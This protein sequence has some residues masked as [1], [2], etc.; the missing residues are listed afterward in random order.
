MT[1]P[2]RPPGVP[3][4][5]R[6][7][8]E[9]EENYRWEEG[10]RNERGERHG[11]NR[12]WA[13][14]GYL[15]GECIYVDGKVEGP[16]RVFHPDGRLASVGEW[17]GGQ[18]YDVTFY[19]ARGASP[20]PWPPEAGPGVASVRYCSRDAVSNFATRY[21]DQDGIEVCENGDPIPPR[22]EGVDADAGFFP[23][24]GRWIVGNVKR[25]ANQRVG[26]CKQWTKD[27]T[28]LEHEELDEQGRMVSA[29]RYHESGALKRQQEYVGGEL[30]LD[31]RFHEDGTPRDREEFDDRGRTTYAADWREN[32]EL[33]KE[34]RAEWEGDLLL[35]FSE[36][37]EDGLLCQAERAGDALAC[38]L[39]DEGALA[40]EGLVA[41]GRRVGRW[42]TFDPPGGAV[43]TEADLT[44]HEVETDFAGSANWKDLYR[45]ARD[46]FARHLAPTVKAPELDGVDDIAWDEVG[47]CYGTA[48]EFPLLLRAV[49][50]PDPFVRVFGLR[51]I[52]RQIEHQGSVYPATAAVVPFLIR[53]LGNENVA[54]ED[55][56]RVLHDVGTAASMYRK[57][58]EESL[59]RA[60]AKATA[61]E[62][63]TPE[64]AD[65]EDPEDV[66]DNDEEAEWRDALLGTLDAIGAGL[67]A[68]FALAEKGS[69]DQRQYI[70]GLAGVARGGPDVREHL[71]A[72][73]RSPDASLRAMASHAGV[74]NGSLTAD[75]GTALL[76]D[77]APV[78][79][80]VTAFAL[81]RR[82]GPGSPPVVV[83]RLAELVERW[84]DVNPEF[85]ALP[86]V[87]EHLL[88][89]VALALGVIR[90][91]AAF[92]LAPALCRTIDS[93]DGMSAS[94]CGHGLLALAFGRCQR[95][96]MPGFLDVLEAL[97]RSTAFYTFNVDASQSL[98][99]FGIGTGMAPDQ[100]VALVARLRA[101]PDPEATLHAIMHRID[102]RGGEA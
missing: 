92:A 76:G 11:P 66:D 18:M 102:E 93:L 79:R 86:I 84:E 20:E 7:E 62:E 65:S 4:S 37:D 25:G 56:L 14:A 55:V 97:S 60:R 94:S 1:A 87:Q 88:S 38:R 27:G 91:P 43:R 47:G 75:D 9:N 28:L 3:A 36:R 68:L 80:A 52:W 12:S 90:S 34:M 10:A 29:R 101:E 35:S 85:R 5:A 32:G 26:T 19:R 6:F 48:D 49:A 51:E 17:K 22:P 100:L 59:E 74:Q 33:Q 39:Y 69:A 13:D 23:S 83:D 45:A 53:L 44:P 46:A 50:V 64:T 31:A 73:T 15:H 2:S 70:V 72:W 8:P 77:P 16:N 99:K 61:G 54:R 40:A 30:R 21:F 41:E 42:R 81:A 82:F 78:V 58:A 95:P 96:F 71:L 63:T 24:R 98:A 67:P 57:Q 89:H